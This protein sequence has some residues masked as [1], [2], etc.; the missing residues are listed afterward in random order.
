MPYL[1]EVEAMKD[2][3]AR[4]PDHVS[5]CRKNKF[6]NIRRDI[7]MH[8]QQQQRR[9]MMSHLGVQQTSPT[10]TPIQF[11]PI[12]VLSW[13]PIE[14]AGVNVAYEMFQRCDVRGRQAFFVALACKLRLEQPQFVTLEDGLV[15]DRERDVYPDDDCFLQH[16]RILVSFMRRLWPQAAPWERPEIVAAIEADS[17]ISVEAERYWGA[18]ASLQVCYCD[19]QEMFD[20]RRGRPV[21]YC[22]ARID[23]EGLALYLHEN[24]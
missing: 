16:T 1:F 3:E 24:S 15:G 10:T 6:R 21:S 22:K 19:V 4:L 12:D 5:Q 20:N 11:V 7:S 9:K 14:G 8:L 18:A 17:A 23:P 13:V 2:I